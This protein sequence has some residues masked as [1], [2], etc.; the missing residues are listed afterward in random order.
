MWNCFEYKKF[1]LWKDILNVLSQHTV[2]K[3]LLRI[4]KLLIMKVTIIQKIEFCKYFLLILNRRKYFKWL[5]LYHTITIYSH[6]LRLQYASFRLPSL[7]VLSKSF[8]MTT[9]I[10]PF[11]TTYI[12]ININLFISLS[13]IWFASDTDVKASKT[14][15]LSNENYDL[16]H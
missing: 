12:H 7:I 16:G 1:G 9:C 3:H 2:D 8:I 10:K 13:K 4:R 5:S 6:I 14:F 11:D 15:S